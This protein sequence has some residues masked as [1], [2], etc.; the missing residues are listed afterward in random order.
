[1]EDEEEDPE[2]ARSVAFFVH[3]KPVRSATEAAQDEY[4]AC[5]PRVAG[6]GC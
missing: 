2:P 6:R 1:M 4:F 3:E 5:R